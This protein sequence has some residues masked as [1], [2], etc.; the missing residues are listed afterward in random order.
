MAAVLVIVFLVVPLVELYV[1]IQVGDAIGAL[2]TI[3]VLIGMGVAGG[4]LMKREGLGVVRRVQAQLR[5]G[6]VPGR[7]VVDGFL[8]LFGGALMLTPGFLTDIVGLS[9]L[10]PPVRALVRTV[11]AQRL[12][13]HVVGRRGGGNSGGQ[14]Y[15]DV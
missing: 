5:G 13:S 10:V 1:I 3:A 4:Y 9:L 2:N 12:R 14:N 11:V 15:L 6:H 7:E 8:I